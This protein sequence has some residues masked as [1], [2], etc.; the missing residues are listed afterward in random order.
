MRT[1]K[2]D[3]EVKG[4]DFFYTP[5]V[6]VSVNSGFIEDAILKAT[7]KIAKDMCVSKSLIT[8]KDINETKG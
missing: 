3:A 4:V 1:F 6:E 2:I 8:V 5:S 7:D